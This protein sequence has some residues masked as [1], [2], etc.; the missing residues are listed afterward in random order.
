VA[1]N[2]AAFPDSDLLC[3]GGTGIRFVASESERI[4]LGI[5]YARASD[6]DSAVYFRIGEAF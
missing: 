6:G 1:P 2:L 5:D 3:S 4:N